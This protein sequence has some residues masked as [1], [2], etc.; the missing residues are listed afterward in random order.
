MKRTPRTVPG[1]TEDILSYMDAH[2]TRNKDGFAPASG[3]SAAS[4]PEKSRGSAVRRKKG[5]VLRM[6]LDLH[7]LTSEEATCRIRCAIDS[8]RS[9]GI[10]ELL[11]IHG[12]GLHSGYNEGPVLK[13]LVR[14]MLDNELVLNVKDF[15]SG[16]PREGGEGVTLVF[17]T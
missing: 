7:C 8:C 17:L 6:T 2:G 5:G 4:A 3:G 12:R 9:R 13:N 1:T 15:R 14:R 11:V 16:L 10:K